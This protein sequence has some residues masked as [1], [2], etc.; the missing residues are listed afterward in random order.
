MFLSVFISCNE[1]KTETNL[2]SKLIGVKWENSELDFIAFDSTLVYIPIKELYP[3]SCAFE[4]TLK[5][6]TLIII[7]KTVN[8]YNLVDFNDTISFLKIEYITKDSLRLKSINS[9]ANELLKG[10]ENFTFYNSKLLDRYSYYIEKDSVCLKQIN[11]AKA[12]I[13]QNEL[14]FCF[15]PPWPFRQ[16]KEFIKLLKRVDIS[17][18]DLG[19]PP[20]VYPIERNCYRET[21]NYYINKKFGTDFITNLLM[22]ADTLMVNN[23]RADF[24]KY[25]ACDVRP[26]IP[27]DRPRQNDNM[28]TYV[29][30]P[31]KKNRKEWTTSKGE[32]MFAVYRPFIDIR[33][34]IDT[35]GEISN[36]SLTF[37]NPQLKWNKQFRDKLFELGVAKIKENPI[38]IPGKI[39][40]IEVRTDNNVR[41][42][43]EQEN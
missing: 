8:A 1:K 22:K 37:F 39:L 41:M 13:E 11:Q 33:F 18:K 34:D 25:Y 12:Q 16:E 40:G 42:T 31:V 6:D 35:T 27:G 32:K 5:S 21:M 38:W 28:T 3:T 43:F 36:F 26:H 4:Y 9:G 29:D 17:Y 30:L 23:S 7:N 24:F 20:D 2:S 14:V 15:H 19:P 10:F